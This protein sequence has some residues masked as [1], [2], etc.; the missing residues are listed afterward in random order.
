M[1]FAIFDIETRIDKRLLNQTYFEE[2]LDDEVAY[3]RWRER[4]LE[5]NGGDFAPLPLHLPISIA[6][7]TVDTAYVLRSVDSLGLPSYS[8]EALTREFW[9]RAERFDGCLVTFNGRR[10]DWPVLELCALRYGIPAASHFENSPRLCDEARHL[11]LLDFLTNDGAARLRGGIDLLLKMIG[12]P[13]K[14][15]IDGSMVQ[16]YYDAG[17]LDEIHRYC[18][19]DV[20]QTYF[21]FLRVQLIRG[22]ITVVDYAA[23]RAASESFINE[24]RALAAEARR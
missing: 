7:G 1:A 15:G 24:V 14:T 5:H 4:Q 10:F 12:M 3:Q 21:L 20:I 8:E 23:A 22:R 13:G 18:R 17:R 2:R 9:S 11:D 16:D 19:A 6:I